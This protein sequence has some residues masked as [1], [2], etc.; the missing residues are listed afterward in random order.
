[1]NEKLRVKSH[2]SVSGGKISE[3]PP[4]ELQWEA[5]MLEAWLLLPFPF[6]RMFHHDGSMALQ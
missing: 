4:L 5:G 6:E 1:M 3:I 2:R